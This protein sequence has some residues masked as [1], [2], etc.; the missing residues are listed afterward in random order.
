MFQKG[1]QGPF[2]LISHYVA[3]YCFKCINIYMKEQ[4]QQIVDITSPKK[5]GQKVKSDSELYNWVQL[6]VGKTLSEKIYN[7][8]NPNTQYCELGNQ[9]K[10]KSITKGYGFCGLA[11]RCAC[12]R[13]QVSEK[14][15]SAKQQY[16]LSQKQEIQNKR[17]ATVI[18]KYGVNNVGQLDTAKI[19]RDAI[20]N[21]SLKVSEITKKVKNTKFE[22]YNNSNY[23]NVD[24]IKETFK[25]KRQEQFWVNRYPD[26]DIETLENKDQLYKLYQSLTP[27]EIADRLNV[28][29][30]TVYRYLNRH[31]LREPFK[32]ADE[33]ELV[34]YLVDLGIKNIVTNTRKV[35]PS[36]KELD[37]YLPDYNI[38]I[39]YNGVYWHHEDIDHITRDYHYN[40]FKEAESLGIQLITVFSNFWHLKK[41]IVKQIIAAKLG[42]IDNEV[43][44]ARKCHVKTITN[45]ESKEFLNSFHI[46]GYT[47]AEIVLGLYSQN[48]LVAVMTF[49]KSRT[50]I[51]KNSTDTELV[52]FS[53][54]GRVVG[55]ASK[56]LKLYRTMYPDETII[57][58]SDNEW[59][60]GH[61]YQTLGFEIESEVKYS[62]WYLKP[63]EH[64]LYHRFNFSK[65]KLVKQGYDANKSESQITKELGLLKV[66]DC[67]KRKWRLSPLNYLQLKR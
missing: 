53:S 25:I 39:E 36:K 19:S 30:Q 10:F 66:W 65:Q 42:K 12:A 4:L 59:S 45:T 27:I 33:L 62:Y 34:R 13:A 21:D 24:Q 41:P 58:Y 1:P 61:L 57:S 20:Y 22:R 46:Q 32:S 6:H 49:S 63:R 29:V 40:K 54:R 18:D 60:T 14:V 50:G 28:H 26:K 23:N 55:G 37:I 9:K 48:Q 51:G 11:G 5:I 56:L 35:L 31:N 52:R 2:C 17:Q 67:G 64:R 7:I 8:L 47:P 38:A 3:S 16:S 44:Y 43:I 15:S